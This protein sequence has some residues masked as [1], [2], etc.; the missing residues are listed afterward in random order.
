MHVPP[1]DKRNNLTHFQWGWDTDSAS[2]EARA[3]NKPIQIS[4]VNFVCPVVFQHDVP[5]P[6]MRRNLTH[7]SPP[8]LY[9]EVVDGLDV[10]HIHD[11]TIREREAREVW[12]DFFLTL[13]LSFFP[14]RDGSGRAL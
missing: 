12:I 7:R 1:L 5:I 2:E 6:E 11:R 13:M 8:A 9:M 14:N 10:K 3:N 4:Q